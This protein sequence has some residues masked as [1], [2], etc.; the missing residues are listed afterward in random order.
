MDNIG[1]DINIHGQKCVLRNL[2]YLLVMLQVCIHSVVLVH[3]PSHAR[4]WCF[5]KHLFMLVVFIIPKG[6]IHDFNIFTS[7]FQLC[8]VLKH[9]TQISYVYNYMIRS[10]HEACNYMS[11]CMWFDFKTMFDQIIKCI[12]PIEKL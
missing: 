10:C 7:K 11:K 1:F 9:V 4:S 6:N 12:E 5:Y 2:K 3:V 8:H